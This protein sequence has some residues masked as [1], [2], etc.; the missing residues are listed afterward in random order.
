MQNSTRV[1]TAAVEALQEA[2][3]ERL[4]SVVL[5]GSRARREGSEASDWDL[6]VI[7]E[8]LP[9]QAFERHICLKR[10]LPPTWRGAISLL[11][12][13]PEEFEARVPAL[14]LDV[15]LDGRI[16]YDPHGYAAR[17]LA[18]LRHLIQREGLSRERTMAGDV[19]RWEKAPSQPWQ[20]EWSR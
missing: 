1:T 14:F 19:W 12:K 3:G 8:G 17:R 2:L 15:A 9:Q 5:F 13:T 11:A 6:L 18:E 20:L 7:A 16:L 10:A 4:L